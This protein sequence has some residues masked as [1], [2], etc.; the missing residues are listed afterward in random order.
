MSEFASAPVFYFYT[1]ILAP[2]MFHRWKMMAD[3]FPGSMVILT[4]K[5][6]TD[7][8]WPYKTEEMD[9]PC[10]EAQE[11]LRWSN[12]L[13]WSKE[14]S[15]IVKSAADK[16]V[17]HLIECISGLN[18]LTILS[19]AKNNEFVL[20]NDG[21]FPETTQ[22]P[23]QKLRWYLVGK[24]CFAAISP[25]D[26]G[27]RYMNAWGFPIDRIYN[28]YFSHD[29]PVYVSF[30]DSE[31]YHLTRNKLRRELHIP[32][33]SLVVICV[34]RLLDWKRIEDLVEA[35]NLLPSPALKR[36][37]VMVI[38]DGEFRKPLEMLRASDKI[39]FKWV[40]SV[41]YEEMKH[42][43]A[44]SDFMT[45]PSEGDIWGICVNEA[46]SMG[47]PVICTDV[48]GAAELV[49]NNWNGFQVPVRKPQALAEAITKII[50]SPKLLSEMSEN[51]K[52]IGNTWHSGLFIDELKRMLKDLGW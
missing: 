20:I 14:L 6:D 45:H 18:T 28:S 17:I 3:A 7:R 41:S 21:G 40:P 42:Y 11:S 38:G 46:L 26:I 22:R 51:A 4:R 23:S 29:I 5:V 9:F 1:N 12:H 50:A 48:I 47:K 34:S 37:F 52:T 39:R 33:D 13:A 19:A 36:L 16:P 30:R 8:P 32:D 15:K 43:Y 31:Q 2:Y 49:K 25:G 27:R 10:V 35:L 24:R 44:A